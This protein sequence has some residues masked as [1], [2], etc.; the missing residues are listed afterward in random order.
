NWWIPSGRTLYSPAR[1]HTE[2]EELHYAR[3]HYFLPCRYRD[4]FHNDTVSTETVVR[5]DPYDVLL[6]ETEDALANR[7]TAGKRDATPSQTIVEHAL[8][9]RV[10]QPTTVMDPNRNRSAVAFDALGMVVGSA[11]MGKP[12]ENLGDSLDGFEADLALSVRASHLAN[13]VG[14]PHEILAKAATRLA[15]D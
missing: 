12:E 7:I 15:Y 9:Y 5:Y 3:N 10:L 4:P 2:A 14:N 6:Q 11:L 1:D 13:P 8:D